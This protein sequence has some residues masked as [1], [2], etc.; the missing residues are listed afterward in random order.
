MPERLLARVVRASDSRGRLRVGGT[1]EAAQT[2]KLTTV[3]LRL[4]M[5][6]HVRNWSCENEAMMLVTQHF[7]DA[8]PKR[9]SDSI[10]IDAVGRYPWA[11][12]TQSCQWL[13][14]SWLV[15][16]LRRQKGH[17]VIHACLSL[18]RARQ[19]ESAIGNY[20]R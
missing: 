11:G 7:D 12:S 8:H 3:V 13:S 6:K 14:P 15:S 5:H 20:V 16:S 18:S 1:R 10:L 19:A 2:R 4:L 9:P 17:D